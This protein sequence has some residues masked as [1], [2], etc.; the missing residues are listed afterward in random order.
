MVVAP[1]GDRLAK[2][3]GSATIRRLREQGVTA[4]EVIATLARG[5][6]LVPGAEDG[7]G[8][9]MSPSEVAAT[10]QPPSTWRRQ[11]WPMPAA[12]G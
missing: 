7:S 10:L 9:G 8:S 5:L 2:R 6:G 4:E 11:P 12:W 3:A 1:D